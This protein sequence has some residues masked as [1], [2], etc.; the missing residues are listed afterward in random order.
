MTFCG[1]LLIVWELFGCDTRIIFGRQ[2]PSSK[3]I[4]SLKAC[5]MTCVIEFQVLFDYV[6]TYKFKTFGKF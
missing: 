4:L 1:H 3:Y 6:F 5:Y 2:G